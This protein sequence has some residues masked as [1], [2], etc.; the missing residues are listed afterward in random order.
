MRVYVDTGQVS[1]VLFT[2][3]CLI[4]RIQCIILSGSPDSYARYPKWAHSFE[5]SLSLEFKTEQSNGLL[6]YTDD[7]NVNGNFY[8]I[9]IVDGRVQLDFRLG[10]NTNDFGPRRPVNTFRI[11]EVQVDDNRWHSLSIFQS[12]ENVK[13]ELD[14]TL[15]PKIL[16]QRSFVFGDI[17]KNSDVF[18]GGV[19]ADLQLLSVMSSPLRRHSRHLAG[20]VRNL[21]YRQYP[22]G[23]T[24]PQL[25]DAVGARQNEDDNCGP[26]PGSSREQFTCQN[27][28]TCYNTNDGPKC[29]CSFSEFEGRQCEIEKSDSELTFSGNEWIGYDVSN[30]ISSQVR[31]KKENFT[32]SFKTVHGSA[33]LFFAGDE[34]SFLHLMIENGA[35]IATSKFDGTEPRLIRMFNSY[36]AERFDDDVWHTVVL[37]RS[38]QMMTLTVDGRKDEIRQYA[39]ELDWITN[40]FAFVGGLPKDNPM[41]GINRSPFRGCLKKVKYDADSQR[42]LFVN[43]ADQGFGENT[44]QTGGE[45]SFSCK[46]PSQPPDILSFAS[47]KGY[48]PLPKW[49]SL[50][51]GSLSFQ[52]RSSE[53]DGLLLYHGM[54]QNN[55]SDYLA[56]E[57]VDGHL[58]MIINLGSGAVKLQTTAK[59]ISTSS[60]E[61][62]S[63]YL[64]RIARTG[65][66]VVDTVKT[67][68]HTPG[69]SSNLIID[70]PIYLGGLPRFPV[71]TYPSSI[72]SISLGKGFQGCVK[73]FRV[74]GISSKIATIFENNNSTVGISLGC[75][76]QNSLNPCDPNPCKNYGRCEPTLAAFKCHC[77]MTGYEG[78]TCNIE[79]SPVEL[80]GEQQHVYILPTTV[81]S[82]A[83]HVQFRFKTDFPSG[84]ILDT[85]SNTQI[86]HRFTVYM[87]NGALNVYFKNG[88]TNNTFSWGHGLSDNRWHSA[89]VRRLG[90]RILLYLDGSWGHNIILPSSI[91]IQ[92]DEIGPAR[93]LHLPDETPRDQNF[94]GAISKLVLN[95]VD[96]MDDLR[97]EGRSGREHK[98]QRNIKTKPFTVSFT[99]T[100]GYLVYSSR[101]LSSLAGTF[102][103]QF[104]FQTLIRSALL[105]ATIPHD[106]SDQMTVE[107]VNGRIRYSY[108]GWKMDDAIESPKLPGG[109]HLS[110]LRWHNILLYQ[111]EI[112]AFV[113]SRA[114]SGADSGR[115]REECVNFSL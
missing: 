1:T 107:L 82:E 39:P 56:F 100:S 50:S 78:E 66:V 96:L 34:K 84:V 88:E 10:D 52:F 86:H 109:Q 29:D 2:C 51:S 87:D 80:D 75:L 92:R 60:G 68:F 53:S 95:E 18:I 37:E 113:P 111:R 49:N 108:K 112:P 64:E 20:N 28:G 67:D 14:Y 3:C 42:I 55:A 17:H 93:S 19:P 13:L 85:K 40:A 102:R 110:D 58:F 48:L 22:Q 91:A 27:D 7:G 41:R 11:E 46:N 38:L 57:L 9:T 21:I 76:M 81:V 69:I 65:S 47:G 103:V 61:W 31:T 94:R 89:Q 23:I 45:L 71:L 16:N 12:W 32:L 114:R 101:K 79:P 59:K 44:I 73:N 99:N 26:K 98:G 97:R 105:L 70:D 74:N 35:L 5:N 30:L 62:H 25:L 104:K 43:I 24:S 77:E 15:V 4:V 83:E 106:G 8:S 72:W 54:M 63:V 33:M 36:P 115:M 90:D 6:L